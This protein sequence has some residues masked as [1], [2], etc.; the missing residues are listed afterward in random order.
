MHRKR[1][2]RLP[3]SLQVSTYQCMGV[4]KLSKARG[5]KHERS[6]R[7]NPWNSHKARSSSCSCVPEWE[8][9]IIHDALGRIHKRRKLGLN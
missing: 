8:N 2:K 6:K 9:L 5:K 1:L 3:S 4:R 7:S